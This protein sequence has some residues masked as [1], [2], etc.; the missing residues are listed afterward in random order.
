MN[1]YKYFSALYDELTQDM[2]YTPWIDIV[3]NY[4][5]S[6]LD[7]G[8]GSGSLL[9]MLKQL[10]YE[11]M[12]IDLSESMIE[13]AKKKLIMNH[14]NIPLL[15]ENMISFKLEKKFDIITCFFDTL[16]HLE[17]EEDF[18]KTLLNLENHLSNDGVLIIDLF[19][20][21]KMNDIDNEEFIFDENT[22][23]AKWRMNCKNNKIIHNLFFEIGN[24]SKEE[25]YIETYFDVK[26]ILP[27]T[28][29]IIDEIPI[30]IDDVCERIV[31]IIKK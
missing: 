27:N 3:K 9:I 29:T 31:Y 25:T 24:D 22:Y 7:V 13:L 2:D 11:C 8:C 18:K 26:K 28:L 4:N 16:N 21:D 19:T 20:Q 1:D 10:D 23:Y 5:G 12:G 30:I 14:M 6:L 17:S 15:I